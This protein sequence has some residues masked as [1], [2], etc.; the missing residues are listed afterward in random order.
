[1]DECDKYFEECNILLNFIA[2]L[3]QIRA[4]LSV[5]QKHHPIY[6]LFSATIQ[7]PVEEL[8]KEEILHDCLRI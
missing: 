6:A 3:E 2:F 1:L 5:F 7:H 8:L 4:F